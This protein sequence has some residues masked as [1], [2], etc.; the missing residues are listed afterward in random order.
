MLDGVEKTALRQI[1]LINDIK[2]LMDSTKEK[3]KKELPKIYSK[4]LLE[5]LFMYPYTKISMLEDSL[6]LHRET[7][8]K[9]LKAIEKIGILNSVK[10]GRSVFY[11]NVKLFALLQKGMS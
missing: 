5:I 2:E 4:D 8:S 11:V 7:A 1:E 9:H 10:L 6:G 3:L